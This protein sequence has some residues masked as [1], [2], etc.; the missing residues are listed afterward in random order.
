VLNPSPNVHVMQFEM[1]KLRSDAR[2]RYYDT[3]V[4]GP[5][6]L[7]PITGPLVQAGGASVAF[8]WSA[9]HDGIVEDVP[10]GTDI[11]ACDGH[12][13]LRWACVLR[14]NLFTGA[15]ARVE[16]IQVPFLIP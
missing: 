8:S 11:N 6:Y 3:A 16:S 5:D 10:F 4:A 13:Y 7:A 12:R 14:A 1:A 15:R 9:S 2:S